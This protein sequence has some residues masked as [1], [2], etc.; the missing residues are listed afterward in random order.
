MTGERRVDARG[1]RCPL[2]VI[3]LGK[4]ARTAEPGTA[5]L[6][7]SDDAAAENDIAAWCA[8]RGCRLLSSEPAADGQGGTAYLV[9]IGDPG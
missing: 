9:L 7:L 1:M 6:L 2:P 4:A 8:M 5:V 3:E